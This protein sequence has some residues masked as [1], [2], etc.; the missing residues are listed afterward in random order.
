[1]SKVMHTST[2][3][4]ELRSAELQCISALA[5]PCDE[6]HVGRRRDMQQ[7]S[8]FADPWILV[9]SRREGILFV[10]LFETGSATRATAGLQA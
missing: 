2:H 9:C 4:I 8:S 3:A 5:Y 1:M 6:V 7:R 10:M